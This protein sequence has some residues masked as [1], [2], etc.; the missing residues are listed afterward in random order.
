MSRW[1]SPS[2]VGVGAVPCFKVS[3]GVVIVGLDHVILASSCVW[4]ALVTPFRYWNSALLTVP[5]AI[6]AAS[7]A[8]GISPATMSD[9]ISD[10]RSL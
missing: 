1:I 10:D 4:I 7:I 9:L 8:E 6:L 3:V 5:S 2:A